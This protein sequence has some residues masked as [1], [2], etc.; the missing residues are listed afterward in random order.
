MTRYR[1]NCPIVMSART[2]RHLITL[3]LAAAV[4]GST[5]RARSA[6]IAQSARLIGRVVDTAGRPAPGVFVTAL[7]E[8]GGV[9]RRVLS[10]VDGGY[11]FAFLPE[12]TYRVDFEIQG[13][14]LIRRNHVRV[15]RSANDSIDAILSVRAMCECVHVVP[16]VPVSE[17]S[18]QV[19]DGEGRPL[20]HARVTIATPR[21]SEVAYAD[22][23]GRF[24][25]RV[26]IGDK[27]SLT[28]S[29]SGFNA[30]TLQV[31][32]TV[33]APFQLALSYAGT[34]PVPDVEP[35]NRTCECPDDLFVHNRP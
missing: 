3:T 11:G 15:P 22:A 28:A 18:G 2:L 35:L 17:R 6:A 10:G 26:P 8:S 5:A 29:D 24:R 34:R 12:G 31:S 16:S 9:A 30:V 19:V 13:F 27:W 4:V 32:S 25:V 23:D 20:P 33:P 1:H 7:P 14:Q 21:T